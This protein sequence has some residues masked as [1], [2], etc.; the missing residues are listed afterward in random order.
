MVA[1]LNVMGEEWEELKGN[2]NDSF[3]ALRVIGM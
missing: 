1:G 3:W 2:V